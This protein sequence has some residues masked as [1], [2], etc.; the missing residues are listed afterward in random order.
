MLLL[1]CYVWLLHVLAGS[2]L[3]ASYTMKP[4]HRPDSVRSLLLIFAATGRRSL[5]QIKR[6]SDLF[7]M[8]SREWFHL[9]SSNNNPMLAESATLSALA[10]ACT[11]PELRQRQQ[12]RA[13]RLLGD[14]RQGRDQTPYLGHGHEPVH[15]G[16][17]EAADC[18]PV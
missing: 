17:D 15:R 14:Q 5:L 8:F 16:N 11:P 18:R 4:P 3:T 7:G 2:K 1:T 13:R 9:W 12:L 6:F 10:T